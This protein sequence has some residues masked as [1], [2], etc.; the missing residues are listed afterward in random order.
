MLW[1]VYHGA[2]P[3]PTTR[4]TSWASLDV[5]KILA[6]CL[7]LESLHLSSTLLDLLTNIPDFEELK[8][9]GI[10]KDGNGLVAP[11]QKLNYSTAKVFPTQ[12]KLEEMVFS[13]YPKA[14]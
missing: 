6:M 7:H 14:K 5:G 13:V 3:P 10:V 12:Y 9:I 2:E 8:L 4:Q 1:Q 11:S